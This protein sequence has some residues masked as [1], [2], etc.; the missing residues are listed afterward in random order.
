MG[1]GYAFLLPII[2]N[3]QN[4]MGEHEMI[5]MEEFRQ[6]QDGIHKAAEDDTPY[7]G[8]IDNDLH[9]MGDPNKTEIKPHTYVVRFG[10]PKNEKYRKEKV[11][12]ETENYLIC[13]REYKDVF[14]PVRR[15][16]TVVN[17]FARVEQFLMMITDEGEVRDM[18]EAEAQMMFQAL[19]DDIVDVVADAV[20]KVLGL[21]Q[22]EANCIMT[23][24]AIKTLVQMQTDI[25]EIINEADLFFG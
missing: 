4:H 21:D 9:I 2:P 5:T 25:A 14:I 16:T 3:N 22:F 17:A 23:A 24:S 11:I 10:F 7:L 12:S 13:E 8:V 19:D 15:H 1:S 18:T 6:M 20:A